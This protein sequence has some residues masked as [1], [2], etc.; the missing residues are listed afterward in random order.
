MRLLRPVVL[1]VL[2]A[3]VIAYLA[4]FAMYYD[5]SIFVNW[6]HASHEL[7]IHKI[8]Y[9]STIFGPKYRVVYP[10]LAPTIFIASYEVYEKLSIHVKQPLTEYIERLTVKLPL[11]LGLVAL[12]ILVARRIGFE[13]AY[14]LILL[15]PPL[16]TVIAVYNFDIIMVLLLYASLELALAGCFTLAGVLA[17]FSV[18]SKQTAILAVPAIMVVASRLGGRRAVTR[19]IAG[20]AVS[21]LTAVPFIVGGLNPLFNSV[22]GFH[23]LRPPQG[24]TVWYTIFVWQGY[25]CSFVSCELW[26]PAFTALYLFIL[27]RAV[28]AKIVEPF[29]LVAAFMTSYLALG[30]VVNPVYLSWA[31][32]FLVVSY[33]RRGK[34]RLLALYMLSYTAVLAYFGLLFFSSVS[35]RI[36]VYLPEERRWISPHE[37]EAYIVES[38]SAHPLLLNMILTLLSHPFS[39]VVSRLILS[40]WPYLALLLSVAYTAAMIATFLKLA[41]EGVG[42]RVR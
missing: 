33:G 25:E 21:L 19:L 10:P 38:L 20:V 36:P 18:L 16:L 41:V 37:V 1:G 28:R 27:Y 40:A 6:V 31:Y 8:Y 15:G 23:G 11:I 22:V 35:A 4:G 32:P 14:W 9:A 7:G 13:K 34:G 39:Q 24:P 5:Y 2:A 26:L 30:K 17:G 12:W 3:A 29:S 42:F